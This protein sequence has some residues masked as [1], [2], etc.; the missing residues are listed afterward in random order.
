MATFTIGTPINSRRLQDAGLQ[1]NTAL[2]NAASTITNTNW[3]S[4]TA[5][6]PWSQYYTNNT[7]GLAT[8]PVGTANS[9]NG[10]YVATEK[11]VLYTSVTASANSNGGNL[12]GNCN[13]YL[14]T[15]PV[16]SNGNYDSG[17]ITNVPL[18]SAF[19]GGN[20][21]YTMAQ[22]TAGTGG[23]TAAVTTYDQLPPNI[24]QFIR[25]QCQTGTNAANMADATVT[26]AIL[27]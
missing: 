17:N 19:L 7:G 9:P 23:N 25:L 16:L 2:P 26:M 14:Q 8:P 21:A 10:P 13:I 20:V 27:V 5:P 15:C 24:Y 1:A 4:L 12:S 18:R 11:V 3:V 6:G 22:N